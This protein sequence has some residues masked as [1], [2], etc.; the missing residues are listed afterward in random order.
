MLII[1]F[2]LSFAKRRGFYDGDRHHCGC[3]RPGNADEQP[4][5]VGHPYGRSFYFKTNATSD[6]AIFEAESG[7]GRPERKG[8][9][10]AS[11]AY[12]KR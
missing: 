12:R 1:G 4:R 2:L 8:K 7:G 6:G 9:G 10:S 5:F 11:K 3:C